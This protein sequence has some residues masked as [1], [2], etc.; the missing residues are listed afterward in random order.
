MQIVLLSG[1]SGKRLWPLSNEVRSK[2]F[3]KLFTDKNNQKESIVQRVYKQIKEAQPSA[4]ITVATNNLQYD[5]V[6]EHLDHDVNVVLEPSRR[7]TYPAIALACAY[8]SLEKNISPDETI[9]VLPV[10]PFTELSFFRTLSQMD[11]IIQNNKADLALIGIKPLLP[12]SKYG[13]IIPKPKETEGMYY[14]DMFVEKPDEETAANLINIGSYWNGGVFAFKL[15]YLLS[16]IEK[17][18]HFSSYQDL[19][20]NYNQ[21]EKISFDYKVVEKASNVAVVPYYGKWT[22]IGTWRT[23][24]DE[25]PQ[26]NIGSVVSEKTRN[27]FVINELNIPIITLGTKDIVVVA[28]NDGILVSDLME[29][30]NLK[31]VVEKLDLS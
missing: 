13:Y 23:L 25:M 11:M 28:S 6:R 3:L 16:I 31:S 22:D 30:A 1:G 24:T 14:V 29:S 18:V 2:Q 20:D 4:N 21:L 17:D 12:T 5:C 7:D 10:D 27:T 15:Q 26:V 19:H 9:I 8:L